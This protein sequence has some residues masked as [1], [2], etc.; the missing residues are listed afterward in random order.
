LNG[1]HRDPVAHD[2]F[3][4]LRPARKIRRQRCVWSDRFAQQWIQHRS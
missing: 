2:W 3:Q 1:F 4:T